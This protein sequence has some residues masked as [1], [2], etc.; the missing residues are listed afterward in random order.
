MPENISLEKK[1]LQASPIVSEQYLYEQGIHR[2]LYDGNYKYFTYEKKRDSE[3]Y[4]IKRDPHEME[5]LAALLPD[6]TLQMKNSLDVW[7]AEHP[8]LVEDELPEKTPSSELIQ[9]LKALGYIQ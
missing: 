9:G 6:T 7:L 8:D 1:G 4:N 3:L 2:V 5:D